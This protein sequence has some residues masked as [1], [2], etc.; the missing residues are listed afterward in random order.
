M[1]AKFKNIATVA[2]AA[3]LLGS[4]V[5][6]AAAA[7]DMNDWRREVV[8]EISKKQTYPRSALSAEIE[9]KAKVRLTVAPDGAITASEII[10]PTGQ[11]VLDDEI[12]QLINRLNPLPSLP[13]GQA[14]L[15]FVLPLTWSLD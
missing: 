1:I 12:P 2:V 8:S 14:A 11:Q 6:F 4:T 9:G 3:A 13:E 5:S 15:T 7:K 10:E